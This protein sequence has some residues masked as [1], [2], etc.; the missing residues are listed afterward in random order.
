M[1]KQIA[2]LLTEP[3]EIAALLIVE[4]MDGLTSVERIKLH[5]WYNEAEENRRLKEVY[6]CFEKY[7]KK[8]LGPSYSGPEFENW[9]LKYIEENKIRWNT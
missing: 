1:T 8:G 4:L 5:F 7:V 3:K 2:R 6:F 9:F